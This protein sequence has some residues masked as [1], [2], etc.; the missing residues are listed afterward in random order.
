MPD[1][2]VSIGG[3]DLHIEQAVAQS[4]QTFEHLWQGEPGAESFLVEIEA[5]STQL[6]GPVGHVP[7]GERFG[8][9]RS[10]ACCAGFQFGQ[11]PFSG[12]EGCCP[13]LL[14]QLLHSVDVVSHLRGQAH[15]GPVAVAEALG[16]FRAKAEDFLDER[17][18]VEVTIAGPAHVGAIDGFAQITVARVGEE[19]HV[20]RHVEP[21][22]PGA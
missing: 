21:Q 1:G 4:E 15:V 3:M 10:L 6:F 16:L 17:A 12:R 22:Q 7:G 20:A 2:C 13:Q 11:F 9:G 8:F 14:Q 19:R 18:V 5:F